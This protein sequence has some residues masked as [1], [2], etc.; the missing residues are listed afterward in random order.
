[1]PQVPIA[2]QLFSVRKEC[3]K[4]LPAVLDAV[5]KVGYEGVEFAGYYGR[6]AEQLESLL[7]DRGLQAVGTHIGVQTLLGAELEK[8]VEFNKT[9]G[10][11]YLIVP[12]LPREYTD[13]LDAW[14]RTADLFNQLAEKVAD[15][16]LQVGYHNHTEEFKKV[17]GDCAWDV[18]ARNTRKDVVLQLDTGNALLGGG[19]VVALLKAYPGRSTT[20]HLKE[21]SATNDKAL[22]GE[23]DIPWKEVFRLC[24]TVGGT[25]WYIVEQETYAY[26]PL[27][28]VEKCLQNLRNMGK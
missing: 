28:T 11:R 2:L 4:D 17:G 10:N 22:I 3:E 16:D 26:P 27:T 15:E 12:G 9:I 24:E 5:A 6:T 18:F 8:T 14:K 21:H 19:D 1:M 20:V 23:G 13:S 25:E 7:S